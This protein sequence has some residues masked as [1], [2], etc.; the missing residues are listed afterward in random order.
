MGGG[1]RPGRGAAGLRGLA[2]AASSFSDVL[3]RLAEHLIYCSLRKPD[4]LPL[5]SRDHLYVSFVLKIGENAPGVLF[6]G[7]ARLPAEV[8]HDLILRGRTRPKPRQDAL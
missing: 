7:L 5:L 6:G 4:E 3:L 2:V 1:P 8:L